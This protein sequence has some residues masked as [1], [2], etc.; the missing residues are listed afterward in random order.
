MGL[1][2]SSLYYVAQAESA[3]NLL[4]MRLMDEE[5]MRH[6]FYGAPRLRAWLQTQGH[7]V[8]DK[9]IERL[10]RFSVYHLLKSQRR[11]VPARHLL[12]ITA[13]FRNC[14][15]HSGRG[16]VMASSRKR[17]TIAPLSPERA[18]LSSRSM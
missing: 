12:L 7:N 18:S 16:S 4:L 6:P 8:N 1:A 11:L 10:M 13:S 15:S 2:R 5:Y 14:R 17:E 9:R 3:E